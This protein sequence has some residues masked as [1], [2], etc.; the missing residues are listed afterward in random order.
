MAWWRFLEQRLEV[1]QAVASRLANLAV[2]GLFQLDAV[3]PSATTG[4][5]SYL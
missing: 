1:E 3:V 5:V 4:N 2:S